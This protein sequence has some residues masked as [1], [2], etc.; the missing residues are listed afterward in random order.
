MGTYVYSLRAPKRKI[1]LSNNTESTVQH[2]AYA[3]KEFMGWE[4]SRGYKMMEGRVIAQA[5]KAYAN[6]DYENGYIV[7]C[8]HKDDDGKLTNLDGKKVYKNLEASILF[9]TTMDKYMKEVGVLKREGKKYV[10]LLT[11]GVCHG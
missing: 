4:A 9:D 7:L 2:F 5:E 3:Y 11:E 10:L 8:D 6:Y 1:K